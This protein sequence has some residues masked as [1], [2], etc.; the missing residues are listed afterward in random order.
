ML[1]IWTTAQF[2]V[3]GSDDVLHEG[4]SPTPTCDP[5]TEIWCFT[6]IMVK[7]AKVC[8]R[9]LRWW[10]EIHL[11]KEE[12]RHVWQS[13]EWKASW[14]EEQQLGWEGLD[15]AGQEG[16]RAYAVRQ[17]NM[18]RALHARFCRLWDRPL[19]PLVSQDDSGEV[20]SFILDP[21]LEEL[22]EEDEG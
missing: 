9:H 16:I 15:G 4:K 18:Q 13:L 5:S 14:W 10:E 6:A 12:M 3:G 19:M 21:V 17:A 22:V 7:W 11:L 8:A 20:A 2:M 1:W